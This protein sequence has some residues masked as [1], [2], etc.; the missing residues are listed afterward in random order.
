MV[1][2]I[3]NCISYF[4]FVLLYAYV[5][6]FNFTWGLTTPEIVLYVWFIILVIDELREVLIQPSSS[7]YRK[8]RDQMENIYN[9]CQITANDLKSLM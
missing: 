4:L 8:L 5:A 1:K 7:L 6:I 3:G 9:R 2:F